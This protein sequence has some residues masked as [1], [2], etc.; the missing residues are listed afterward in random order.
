MRASLAGAFADKIGRAAIVGAS[1]DE[2]VNTISEVLR[3]EVKMFGEKPDAIAWL[4]ESR[5]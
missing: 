4:R 3:S 5:R 2:E 1:N